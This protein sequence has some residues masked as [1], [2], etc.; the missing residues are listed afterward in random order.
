MRTDPAHLID[1]SAA[2]LG[3]L[4]EHPPLVQCIT[5]SVVTNVTANA[6]LAIGAA[7]AMVDIR[8][9]AGL[10]AGIAG[11]LLV[12]LG[13]PAEEQRDAARES[14]A[15]ASVAGTPWVLDPVA[16]GAL[17]VR[18]ALAH[19]L[20][21]ARPTAI[22]GNASEIIALAGAGAGGRG[23]DAADST[24]AAADA[25]TSLA[26][27]HASVVAVSGPVDLITDGRR[28]ARIANGDALLTRITGGGCA[29]G[30]VTAAFLGASRDASAGGAAGDLG[31]RTA[32]A[33]LADPF[34]AT[35]AATVVYT[36]AAELAAERSTGP[37][38]FAVAFLDALALVTPAE[39]IAR[40][41]VTVTDAAASAPGSETASDAA[42]NAEPA[43]ARA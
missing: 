34:V 20:V 42:P 17:P 40:A 4:R 7:P 37:G 13:T 36:I 5:N 30:A 41:K 43:T 9:E 14:V 25:A 33:L 3:R 29:L 2:L 21:A 24:D 19:E 6:L 18:T 8:E 10:F 1:A 38:S 32:G 26:L 35:V 39:V 11:G 16:I 31:E 28:T 27:A 15:A 12:N 23:V 22:R